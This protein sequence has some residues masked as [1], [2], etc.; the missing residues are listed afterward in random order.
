MDDFKEF[1]GK[2]IDVAI[3]EACTYF[4]TDREKLE[5]EII[6]D[7]KTGIFGIVGSRKAIV[8]A[9]LAQ[10]QEAVSSILAQTTRKETLKSPLHRATTER[11]RQNINRQLKRKQKLDATTQA[12][13]EVQASAKDLSPEQSTATTIDEQEPKQSQAKPVKKQPQA[14]HQNHP[15]VENHKDQPTNSGETKES[16]KTQSKAKPKKIAQAQEFEAEHDYDHDDL[17]DFS[18]GLTVVT[19][20]ELQTQAFAELLDETLKTLVAPIVGSNVTLTVQ[21]E[22]SRVCVH[23]ASEED[24]GILIGRDGQTLLSIQYVAARI[25]THKLGKIVHL[26]LDA[27]EYRDRQK[28]KLKE[29]ALA[30]AEKVRATGRTQQTKPLSSYNRRLVHLALQDATDIQTKS[31]GTGGVKRV[32]IMPKR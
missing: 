18:E 11:N 7:A 16:N 6:Q 5:I 31:I 8:K 23:I 12:K 15:K 25:I 2:N 3:S 28:D 10:M 30:L 13:E 32:A 14:R 20:E 22:E 27:G 21:I 19:K 17:A 1:Q 24:S 4:N 26:Q 9:R 29:M